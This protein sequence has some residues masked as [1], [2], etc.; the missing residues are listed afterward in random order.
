MLFIFGDESPRFQQVF[1]GYFTDL[2]IFL[3]IAGFVLV[4]AS[5]YQHEETDLLLKNES[6]IVE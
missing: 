6:I 3:T 5:Y 1:N 2:G 4:I